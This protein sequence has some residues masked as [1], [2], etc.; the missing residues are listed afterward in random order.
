M[1]IRA[2]YIQR[3]HRTL[4]VWEIAG[5][6]ICEGDRKV[7]LDLGAGFARGDQEAWY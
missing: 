2:W 4:G 6:G 3:F 7:G 5:G 1:H